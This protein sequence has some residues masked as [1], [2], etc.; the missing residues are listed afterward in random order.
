M[1]APPLTPEQ[2]AAE[3]YRD[4]ALYDTEEVRTAYLDGHASGYAKAIKAAAV[5]ADSWG[6]EGVAAAIRG[7]AAPADARKC[8]TCE[9]TGMRR[10]R[11]QHSI[12]WGEEKCSDCGGTGL[13]DAGNGG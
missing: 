9:G 2:E 5:V 13:A 8:P 3:R 10:F 12:H 11:Y 7:L 4:R 1:T 6:Q